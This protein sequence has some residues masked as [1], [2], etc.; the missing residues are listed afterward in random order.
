MPNGIANGTNMSVAFK[1]A[2]DMNFMYASVTNNAADS[3]VSSCG[4]HNLICHS[5]KYPA[6]S[7]CY[8]DFCPERFEAIFSAIYGW[9][10]NIV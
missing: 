9:F 1:R 5:S 8:A 7:R 4:L 6:S 2:F 10:A 3:R